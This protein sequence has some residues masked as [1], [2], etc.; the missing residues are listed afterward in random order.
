M[1]ASMRYFLLVTL[2]AC[3]TPAPRTATPV[4]KPEPTPV[5]PTTPAEPACEKPS[6]LCD[7]VALSKSATPEELATTLYGS[8]GADIH[9]KLAAKNIAPLVVDPGIVLR[10]DAALAFP[11]QPGES[12]WQFRAR[13]AESLGKVRVYRGLAV[14]P[15]ELASITEKGI[16]AASVRSA[17]KVAPK[18][19]LD[20]LIGHLMGLAG[21]ADTM[22]SVSYDRAVSRCVAHMYTRNDKTRTVHVWTTE[23]P[24]LDVLSIDVPSALCPAVEP[25]SL[26]CNPPRGGLT[27]AARMY[28]CR[29][30]YDA[31]IES[32]VQARIDP[33]EIFEVKIESDNA[34]CNDV[35]A[36]VRKDSKLR[37]TEQEKFCA[38]RAAN[39][40]APSSPTFSPPLGSRD[41]RPRA[42]ATR[43]RY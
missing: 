40:P 18:L 19:L 35:L 29:N 42:P 8:A 9:V 15:E 7:L 17:E 12:A 37:E 13:F 27:D 25:A 33:A 31:K 43:R 11:S 23:L 38:P 20:Q 24:L 6:R 39:P 21:P 1:I 41:S 10:L 14:T 4:A 32:F 28:A 5:A 16:L 34:G 26:D 3:S 22:L 2:V 30:F 36:Q